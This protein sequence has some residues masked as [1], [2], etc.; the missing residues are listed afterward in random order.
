MLP[1]LPTIS[2]TA[3]VRC[4]P[5]QA[6]SVGLVPLVPSMH[7]NPMKQCFQPMI[8]AAIRNLIGSSPFVSKDITVA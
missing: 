3:G 6:A 8:F 2:E 1:F 5:Q 7:G 4:P